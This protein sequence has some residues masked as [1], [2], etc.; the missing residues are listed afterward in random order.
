MLLA[1]TKDKH[2]KN[3]PLLKNF[4]NNNTNYNYHFD[5]VYIEDLTEDCADALMVARNLFDLK[6]YKKCSHMLKE[7]IDDKRN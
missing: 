4:I 1:I 5:K 3:A 2:L 7:F 6:E